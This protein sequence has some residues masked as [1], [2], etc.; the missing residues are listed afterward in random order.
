MPGTVSPGTDNLPDRRNTSPIG[1]VP[2]Q[3]GAELWSPRR[4]QPY[5]DA[6]GAAP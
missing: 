3:T 6:V 4:P 1:H 5:D 2:W